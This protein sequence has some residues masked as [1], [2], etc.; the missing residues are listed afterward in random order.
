M[1]FVKSCDTC[2]SF[3]S[4]SSDQ[5]SKDEKVVMPMTRTNE[6]CQALFTYTK[7]PQVKVPRNVIGSLVALGATVC[8]FKQTLQYKTKLQR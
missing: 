1:T 3:V 7:V 8:M 4:S 6:E 2:D 5:G